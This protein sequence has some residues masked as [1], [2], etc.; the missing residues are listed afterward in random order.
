[1]QPYHIIIRPIITEKSMAQGD[2]NK[3]QFAVSRNAGKND[4]KKIVEKQFDVHVVS[5]ATTLVKGRTKRIGQ[6]RLQVVQSPWKRA[7]VGL[8]KG[9]KIA[10][11]DVAV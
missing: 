4:I 1:M 5:I 8:K 7:V 6:R 10:I 9:E 11:F 3:Y 2:Q